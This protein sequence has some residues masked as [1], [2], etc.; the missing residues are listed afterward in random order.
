MITQRLP[1]GFSVKAYPG[2]AKTLLAFNLPKALTKNLAGFTVQYRPGTGGPFYLANKLR[3]QDPTKHVQDVT[4]LPTS[5]LNAPIHKFR[6]IH[7]PGSSNQGT[8]PFFGLYTYTVT[9]R[10]FD[11][12]GSLQAIDAKLGVTL[13]IPVGP[14]KKGAVSLGFARGFTQSQAFVAHFGPKG[15]TRPSDPLFDTAKE[16]GKN[17]RGESYTFAD[18]YAWL[19]FTARSQIFAIANEVLANPALS[20]DVFAYDLNEPDLLK[21]FLQL[22]KAGRRIR[23]ILD[24]A[25]LHHDATG[26]KPEDQFEKLF[27]AAAK[28][29][30]EIKRFCFK[31]YAHDKQLIVSDGTGPVKV[32][33]GSTNFSVTGLY[34]NSNHVLV[35]DDR[36]VA[37]TYARVFDTV[38]GMIGTENTDFTKSADSTTPSSFKSAKFPQT[39]V[40][41]SPHTTADATT[42]LQGIATRVAQE[43]STKNGSVLFAVM[44]MGTGSGPV[45]P[46]LKAL[47]ANQQVF[48]YGITDTTEGISLYKPGSAAGILVTGKPAKSVLPPP[49]DQVPSLGLG[50]QVHHK[51]VVCGFNTPNAVVYCGSSNL[52]L[53]GEKENGDNLIALHDADIATAFAIEA[54]GL[55]DHFQFLDGVA[56]NAKAGG[57]VPKAASVEATVNQ[58][59]SAS[60]QQ[61]AAD[62]GWFLSTSDRWAAPYFDPKDLHCV[63]RELFG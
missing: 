35:F 26:K 46:A 40:A 44:E 14:F 6:W 5:S 16:A 57:T 11:A 59:K 39:E 31:R 53:G 7:V 45:F 50:H 19:G 3:F 8:Q 47:H 13:K 55:V 62:A 56:K 12:T 29:P 2:D 27:T 15:L 4:Q 1:N 25:T 36:T 58:T 54:L 37:A 9:P 30:A 41:F 34:V 61:Q 52:A 24:N 22:A 21:I 60:K 49:F 33:T 51:F 23:I 43:S 32:L 17:S 28:G 48:S 10:Y 63:D 38:W 20:L 42:V 18:Q